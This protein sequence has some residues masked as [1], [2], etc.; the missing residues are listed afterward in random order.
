MTPVPDLAPVFGYLAAFCT[1][2]AFLPQALK[3]WR[4][5]SVADLSL[6]T[7]LLFTTGVACWL[8]YGLMTR[9]MPII[10]ANVVTLALAGS[11]LVMRVVFAGRPP[12]RASDR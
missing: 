4:T 6:T 12:T 9:D 7:F 1:T 3:A 8:V 2:V 10:A 5:R 11:I